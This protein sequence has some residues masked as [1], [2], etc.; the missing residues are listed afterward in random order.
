MRPPIT[1]RPEAI[2]NLT[3]TPH[4]LPVNYLSAKAQILKELAEYNFNSLEEALKDLDEK[5]AMYKP[6]EESNNIEWIVNHLCRISRH[7]DPTHPKGGPELQA[8]RMPDDTRTGTTVSRSTWRTSP[9]GKGSP[10]RHRQTHRRPARGGD[11]A[12]GWDQEE[13]GWPLC[14]H[15]RDHPPQGTDS[16]HQ[17]DREALQGKGSQLPR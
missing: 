17:G 6:T 16:L 4:T 3:A 10:R 14:L 11:P 12:L 15:R 13:E 5:E 7:G 8:H 1:L 2:S 9:W